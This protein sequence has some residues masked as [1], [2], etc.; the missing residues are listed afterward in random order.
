MKIAIIGA[1]AMGSLFG[2]K[3]ASASDVCLY[4][5]NKVH[6]DTINEKGLCMSQNGKDSYVKLRATTDAKTIGVVDVALFFTKYTY[7]RSA[8]QDAL[9]CIDRNTLVLSLQNG[10]GCSDLLKEYV[11][12]NQICYGMTAWTSDFKGPGHIELTTTSSVGTWCWPL[13]GIV[14]ER[15]KELEKTMH[16]AGFDFSVT[17]DVDKMIWRK[18]IVNC[19]FNPLSGITQMSTGE[20][21]HNPA[22]YEIIRNVCFEICDVAQ[23]KG[24]DLPRE[25]G[26]KYL[27]HISD[28][29]YDHVASMAL[30]VKNKRLTEI[31]VLNEAVAAEGA[32][33][34]VPTPTVKM[35]AN[36]IRALESQYSK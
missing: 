16:S 1:G 35:L 36:L 15:H 14:D 18:L 32:R 13:N 5:V 2:G 9:N 3:L 12:V 25:E 30:D 17:K 26:L 31:S 6:V 21:F 28:S 27:E 23:A 29:V 20:L 34:G 22:T 7:M 19:N 8:A 33:L 10:L 24:I 11:S 4:D